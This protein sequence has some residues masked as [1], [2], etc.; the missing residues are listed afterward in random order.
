MNHKNRQRSHAHA[1]SVADPIFPEHGTPAARLLAALMRKQRV[2]EIWAW[3]KLG[4]P[5]VGTAVQQLRKL[6]WNLLMVHNTECNRFKEPCRV[7]NYWLRSCVSEESRAQYVRDEA[8]L[9]HE[10]EWGD[11]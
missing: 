11:T 6:G 3:E 4:I 5:R 9:M 8:T 10:A 7:A 2:A 1:D